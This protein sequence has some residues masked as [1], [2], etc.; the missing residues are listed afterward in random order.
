MKKYIYIII[1]T[2]IS[3]KAYCHAEHYKGI[4]QIKMDVLR[5]KKLLVIAIIFLNMR[6]KT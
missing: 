3:F 6:V 5:N 1:F 4:V 2:L